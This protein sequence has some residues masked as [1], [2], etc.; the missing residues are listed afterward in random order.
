MSLSDFS[1]KYQDSKPQRINNCMRNSSKSCYQ[2]W[3]WSRNSGFV[4]MYVED[5]SHHKWNISWNCLHS[6]FLQSS[7]LASKSIYRPIKYELRPRSWWWMLS[8]V[9]AYSL[10]FHCNSL[11]LQNIHFMNKFIRVSYKCLPFDLINF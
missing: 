11:K 2:F 6:T 7:V 1:R 3:L 4:W 5:S 9:H 10:H 8:L